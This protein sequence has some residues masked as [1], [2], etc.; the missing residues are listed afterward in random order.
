MVDFLTHWAWQI[1]PGWILGMLI[2]WLFGDIIAAVVGPVLR[3][4]FHPVYVVLLFVF[5]GFRIEQ[6][7]KQLAID[8][9]WRGE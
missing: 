2:H 8:R 3:F 5:S 4:I 1:I 7:Q 6:V 9:R